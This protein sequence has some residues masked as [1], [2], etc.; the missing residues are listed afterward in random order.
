MENDINNLDP[1]DIGLKGIFGDRFHD[2]NDPKP[3]VKK[4]KKAVDAEWEALEPA[5]DLT[6]KL[7]ACVKHVFLFAALNLIIFYWKNSGLMAE[8]IANPS[9][10]VCTALVGWGVGR[11]VH[12]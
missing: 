2:V 9:M 10:M 7:K 1:D 3:I 4:A 8:S 12:W 6:E 5:P 11:Y